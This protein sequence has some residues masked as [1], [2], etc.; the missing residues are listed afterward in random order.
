MRPLPFAICAVNCAVVILW[1]ASELS[2]TAL[3]ALPVAVGCPSTPW[4]FAQLVLN[5]DSP[6]SAALA[7]DTDPVTARNNITLADVFTMPTRTMRCKSVVALVLHFLSSVRCPSFKLEPP[8]KQLLHPVLN[9]NPRR[10]WISSSTI[11]SSACRT[12]RFEL[13]RKV[14]STHS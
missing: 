8:C 1:T 11:R 14:R 9:A 10:G 2:S 5:S 7:L 3:S 6:V 13:K 4:Q 12:A